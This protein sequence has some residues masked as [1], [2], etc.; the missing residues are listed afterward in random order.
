MGNCS[1]SAPE[2]NEPRE[3]SWKAADQNET[4]SPATADA[5]AEVVALK[6]R[7]AQLETKNEELTAK[8]AARDTVNSKDVQVVLVG[9]AGTTEAEV[10]QAP[11][12]LGEVREQAEHTHAM[13][14][15]M[16]YLP[17]Q[18]SDLEQQ[19]TELLRKLEAERENSSQAG[20]LGEQVAGLEKE[21]YALAGRMRIQL[22]Q[23]TAQ[24]A[25]LR[26]LITRSQRGEVLS[27]RSGFLRTLSSIIGPPPHSGTWRDEWDA[28]SIAQQE[29]LGGDIIALDKFTEMRQKQIKAAVAAGWVEEHAVV[30]ELLI[31]RRAP[32]AKYLSLGDP[33]FAA[34]TYALTDA[35]DEVARSQMRS[36]ESEKCRKMFKHLHGQYSLS[37]ADPAW[38]SLGTPD[39][40]GFNG[41]RHVDHR[42]QLR[43]RKLQPGDADRLLPAGDDQGRIDVRGAGARGRLL[44]VRGRPLH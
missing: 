19:V 33:C 31:R 12:R 22:Q 32:L 9:D 39:Q 28:L 37:E 17:H 24:T 5:T 2:G 42:G 35:I 25:Q 1:S 34:C 18:Q 16:D 29:L 36:G 21:R 43:G 27:T 6:T 26:K 30:C 44:H 14:S 23:V 15:A 7:I 4:T 13:S 3:A 8:R 20:T 11:S 38:A 40:N 41:H 10:F